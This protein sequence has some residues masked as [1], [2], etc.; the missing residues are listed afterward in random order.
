MN[1]T[2]LDEIPQVC[3]E[4]LFFFIVVTSVSTNKIYHELAKV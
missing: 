2:F 4:A 3:I 1:L